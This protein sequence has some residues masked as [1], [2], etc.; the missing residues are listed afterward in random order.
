MRLKIYLL[1]TALG[2]S[3]VLYGEPVHRDGRP[4]PI[5]VHGEND[6]GWHFYNEYEDEIEPEE[7]L[8]E[9]QIPQT[10][11]TSGSQ[12]SSAPE[13]F[14]AAWFNENFTT[15]E[16]RAIDNP[17]KEN[18][19]A[20]LVTERM[21]L[22]KSEVF[23]RTKVRIAQNDPI[24][25]DNT[26]IPM[27]GFGKAAMFKYKKKNYSE[28]MDELTT[29]AGLFF[30]YDGKCIFCHQMVKSLNLLKS[31]HGWEIRVVAR[32]INGNRIVDL[33][34]TIP[35]IRDVRHSQNYRIKHW[36]NLMM[37]VPETKHHY[38]ITQGVMAYTTLERTIVSIALE[39]QVLSDEWFYKI[40]PEEQGLVSQKQFAHLPRD[41]ADDPVRLINHTLELIEN[42]EGTKDY[43]I[44]PQESSNE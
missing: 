18:M 20:L 21:M 32:N 23:A 4:N 35:V 5:V 24:F 8:E 42:P 29:K 2:S 14:S 15:I 12:S 31:M 30:F 9:E 36:P 25:Q 17:S 33:D 27:S 44:T 22:D 38:V 39:Q 26:R 28:A 40:F 41:I 3:P 37:V 10:S 11:Q 6:L 34:P 13:V 1:L 43:T 19:R 16:Q 7:P